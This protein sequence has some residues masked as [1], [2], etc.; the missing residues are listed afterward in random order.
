M[1]GHDVNAPARPKNRDGAS[2]SGVGRN[3]GGKLG[4][5]CP[6]AA[7]RRQ[8]WPAP[9]SRDVPVQDVERESTESPTPGA[10]P[11]PTLPSQPSS[12]SELP[13]QATISLLASPIWQLPPPSAFQGALEAPAAFQPLL[14]PHAPSALPHASPS[15]LPG[16]GG[17]RQSPFPL[18]P[19]SL[20]SSKTAALC[21]RQDC[22][23]L[24]GV[25]VRR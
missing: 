16:I 19:P 20:S 17:S 24:L 10:A 5:Q 15:F 23:E 18:F 7:G 12:A 25:G 13:P 21:F 1:H 9:A 22:A 3:A 2:P 11:E 4:D 6:A 8:L 14:T